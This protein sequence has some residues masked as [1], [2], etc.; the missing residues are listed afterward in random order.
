MKIPGY[1]FCT[2][3]MI[4]LIYG[5]R[6]SGVSDYSSVIELRQVPLK[7]IR[8]TDTLPV[9]A[10]GAIAGDDLVDTY[11]IQAA[12]DSAGKMDGR[13]LILFDKGMYRLDAYGRRHA[14]VIRHSEDLVFN[15][16]GA[17]FLMVRP[18][19]L[20][21]SIDN[22]KRVII[23]DF[24]LDYETSPFTQG[25][26]SE[27]NPEEKWLKV[28]IDSGWPDPF[29]QISRVDVCLISSSDSEDITLMNLRLVQSPA[30][31]LGSGNTLTTG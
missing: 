6:R 13:V 31:M 26:V 18:E 24:E 22:S 14:L 8:V 10:F 20:F 17:R 11:A 12:I 27:V 4:A 29:V 15:G 5:C 21:M 30:C 23:R 19:I 3:L 25:W 28:R 7:D 16:N 1:F 9:S 2:V